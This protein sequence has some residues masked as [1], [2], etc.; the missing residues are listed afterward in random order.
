MQENKEILLCAQIDS[1]ED[2][3]TTETI[4]PIGVVATVFATA[5]TA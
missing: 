3:P 2:E 5:E 4:Y 1:S